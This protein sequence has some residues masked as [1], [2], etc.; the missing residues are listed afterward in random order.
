MYLPVKEI[1]EPFRKASDAILTEV[2]LV[3]GLLNFSTA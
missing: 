2:R 1:T 3:G